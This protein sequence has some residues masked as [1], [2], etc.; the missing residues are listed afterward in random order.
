MWTKFERK[1]AWRYIKPYKKKVFFSIISKFS[2]LGISIGVATLIIVMAIMN[3]FRHELINRIIG[4]NGHIKIN[5]ITNKGF[6]NYNTLKKI[7]KNIPHIHSVIPQISWQA[8]INY[9]YNTSGIQVRGWI[10]KDIQRNMIILKSM[11]IKKFLNKFQGPT[12]IIGKNLASNLG[13]LIGD[14]INLICMKKNKNTFDNVPYIRSFEVINIFNL[15]ID[16]IEQYIVFLPLKEAQKFFRVKKK[17]TNI[18][19]FIKD[20]NKTNIVEAKI[21]NILPN[22]FNVFNWKKYNPQLLNTLE[23]EKNSMFIILTL[24]ILVASFNVISNIVILVQDKY[25]DIAILRTLGATKSSIKKIFILIGIII[26]FYG[27]ILGTSLSVFFLLN[28]ETIK[29]ILEKYYI[30]NFFN[31][32]I[33]FLSQLPVDINYIEILFVVTISLILSFFSTLYPAFS[34]ANLN[35]IDILKNE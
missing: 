28:I 22:V 15:G 17:V 23:I 34:A 27:T 11:K 13:V 7:L 12:I 19:I 32:E 35:P 2:F 20:I 24:I 21:S 1:I 8:I 10:K 25:K 14:N 29:T 4:F 3:G 26:G 33:Y 16:N 31:K 6:D 30:I 18:E 9:K 5:G